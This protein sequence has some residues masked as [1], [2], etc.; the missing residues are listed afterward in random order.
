MQKNLEILKSARPVTPAPVNE[1]QAVV[2]P[3]TFPKIMKND[4]Q[5]LYDPKC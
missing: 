1:S 5:I 3:A 4:G 2:K